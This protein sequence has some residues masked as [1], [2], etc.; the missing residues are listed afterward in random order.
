MKKD[1]VKYKNIKDVLQ[2]SLNSS[3]NLYQKFLW[4]GLPK[5]R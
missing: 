2:K 4:I 1:A 3:I 5:D